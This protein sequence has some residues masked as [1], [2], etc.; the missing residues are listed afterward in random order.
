VTAVRQLPSGPLPTFS[1]EIVI[2]QLSH[3]L[4]ISTRYTLRGA[5]NPPSDGL[6][7]PSLPR[8]PSPEELRVDFR[9][10][11]PRDAALDART[12]NG[13]IEVAGLE[14]DIHVESAKGRV[15]LCTQP[16]R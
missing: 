12:L 10:L 2:A 6:G 11:L 15:V 13:D 3:A 1:I 4:A 9:L 5:D 7:G 8:V 16:L 14:G